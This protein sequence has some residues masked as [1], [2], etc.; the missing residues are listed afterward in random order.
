MESALNVGDTAWMLTAAAM[1]KLMIPGLAFFYGGMVR[2]KS[3][4]NMLMMV[5]GPTFFSSP[6]CYMTSENVNKGITAKLAHA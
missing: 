1:V 5:M 2:S 6:H 4:L 3:V